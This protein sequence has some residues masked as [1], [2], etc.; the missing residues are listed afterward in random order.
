MKAKGLATT[1]GFSLLGLAMNTERAFAQTMD[2]SGIDALEPSQNLDA[3][4]VINNIVNLILYAAGA[5]AVV[6]LIW[7]GLTYITAGGDAEKASKGRVAITNA[8]IGIAIIVGALTIYKL[9][10]DLPG[11][12]AE[13]LK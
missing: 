6:Y 3:G 1:A 5:L 12:G 8:I 4:D 13:A 11:K 2:I 7:G 9:A 10:I